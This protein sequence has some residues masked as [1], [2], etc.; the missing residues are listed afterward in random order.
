VLIFEGKVYFSGKLGGGTGD[1]D[2]SPLLEFSFPFFLYWF[3][4]FFW[5]RIVGGQLYIALAEYRKA[6]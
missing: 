4:F 2:V 1:D 6:D 3:F 5:R